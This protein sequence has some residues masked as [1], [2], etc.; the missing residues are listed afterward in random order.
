MSG[1]LILMLPP[2][3]S[4]GGIASRF[5]R[6]RACQSRKIDHLAT[7][8]LACRRPLRWPAKRVGVAQLATAQRQVPADGSPSSS[9]VAWCCSAVANRARQTRG[10]LRPQRPGEA[11][12]R[13]SACRGGRDRIHRPQIQMA[14]STSRKKNEEGERTSPVINGLSNTIRVGRLARPHEVEHVAAA[15]RPGKSSRAWP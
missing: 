7:K 14:S 5:A 2:W 9:A 3:F 4:Q 10:C 15:D 8:W 12:S 1:P 6:Q 11:S 13:A